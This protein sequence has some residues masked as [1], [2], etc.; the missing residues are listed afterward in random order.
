M[1]GLKPDNSPCAFILGGQGASGKGLL[2]YH[3]A[4][5]YSTVDFLNINGDDFRVYHPD[6]TTSK[7]HLLIPGK[8]KSFLPSL[9]K[10]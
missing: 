9:R 7:Q 1:E 4:H 8:P 6:W 10:D 2:S 5:N 3:I